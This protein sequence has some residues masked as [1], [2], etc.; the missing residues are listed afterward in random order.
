MGKAIAG[1]VIIGF[2]ALLVKAW[3]MARTAAAHAHGPAP[4]PMRYGVII[5]FSAL[6][7][8]ALMFSGRKRNDRPASRS[9]DR[10]GYSWTGRR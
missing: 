6:V 10:G 9:G 3:L 1:L 4:S 7:L 5:G 8:L 2:N